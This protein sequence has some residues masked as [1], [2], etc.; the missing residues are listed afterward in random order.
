MTANI[1]TK[2]KIGKSNTSV[3]ELFIAIDSPSDKKLNDFRKNSEWFA[4]NKDS[5]RKKYGGNYVA[6]HKN[7]ICL[8]DE[9]PTKLLEHVKVKYGHDPS[10]VVS[11]IGKEQ[12]K[13]LL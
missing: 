3:M 4:K 9:D 1:T 5:L 12:V 2:S 13:F 10:V 8:K 6:V 11:F 7:K